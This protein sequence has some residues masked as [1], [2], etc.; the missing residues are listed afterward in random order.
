MT[1]SETTGRNTGWLATLSAGVIVVLI[2]A[3]VAATITRGVHQ[4]RSIVIRLPAGTQPPPPAAT[5]PRC[6]IPAPGSSAALLSG[7]L[8][9]PP[10]GFLRQPDPTVHAGV[11]S[12]AQVA[13]SSHDPG[14][15]AAELRSD[16]LEGAVLRVWVNRGSSAEL[17][18]ILEQFTCAPGAT[19]YFHQQVPGA[20]GVPS[21]E[22][23]VIDGLPGAMGERSTV[24]DTKGH[25]LQVVGLTS[26]S[27][28]AQVSVF[29][30]GADDG[31]L[32]GAIATLQSGRLSPT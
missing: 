17:Q 26:G 19:D 29:T 20:Y 15:A 21:P 5:A 3:G 1:E 23:F 10:D 9:T 4:P 30:S 18:V 24:P 12:S 25:Y 31:S 8:V 28:Y 32:A 2:V 13:A 7:L 6:P 11:L 27:L 14:R 16:G 22:P